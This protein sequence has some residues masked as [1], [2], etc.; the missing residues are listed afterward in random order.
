MVTWTLAFSLSASG[1]SGFRTPSSYTASTSIVMM[2]SSPLFHGRL[3]Q[4][5]RARLY[6]CDDLTRVRV[7]FCLQSAV[8]S[9]QSG[10]LLRIVGM[11]LV[12]GRHVGLGVDQDL[13]DRRPGDPHASHERGGRPPEVVESQ[14]GHVRARAEVL[15]RLLRVLDRAVRRG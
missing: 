14:V 8:Q 4:P 5:V 6:A 11:T 10:P 3:G 2:L 15:G 12:D 13:L 1:R 7:H 9:L